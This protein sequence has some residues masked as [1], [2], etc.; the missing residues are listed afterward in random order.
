MSRP[1]ILV[2]LIALAS[3]GAGRHDARPDVVVIMLDTTRVDHLGPYAET[4]RT[5]FLDRLAQDSVVFENAWTASTCTAPS[6]ASVF[7]G[8][9]PP[10][11][12]LESNILAQA[13]AKGEDETVREFL[14][15][16]EL[17]ALPLS[18]PTL[19]EHLSAVGYQTLGIGSNPNFCEALG[20]SRGFEHFSESPNRDAREMAAELR[21]LATQLE[22]GRPTFTYLHFM[23]P[24]APYKQRA[25]W[26]P[27]EATTE[28]ASLCR[29]RSE[30]AFLD[31]E[32]ESIF[33]EMGWL[34]N[35]DTIV[36]LVTDHGEEFLDHGDIMH[37][38]SVHQELS[39]AGLFLRA[40]GLDPRRTSAPA[41]HTDLLPT[42]LALLDL[43]PPRMLDG[44]ALDRAALEESDTQRP[45]LTC[46]LSPHDGRH[47]W[48]LTVGDWRLLEEQPS[49]VAELYD[50]ARDPKEEHDL[51]RQRPQ[52]F[53][54]M[55][56]QLELLRR[57]IEPV[58]FE[59]V[60]VDLT[61]RLND[62]LSHL[63][64]VGEE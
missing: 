40:P 10:R 5:P 33:G 47:L 42:I 32:L 29:Y 16:I 2:A 31:A 3:C 20:F 48:G 30:I 57:G 43:P 8:L 50:L 12:G 7:T 52:V 59:R 19:T 62:E 64:Y 1:G 23:D 34:E 63:G 41:H 27:H 13:G 38:F 26:C 24:H 56:E 14:S 44:I 9:L 39:R 49:G 37:R 55:R 17:V 45:L 35:E 60:T 22:T 21:R 4:A 15:S 11:H 6:I 25:P 28:C 58:P 54:R 53:S 36:V 61:D 51:A 46:R 18:V